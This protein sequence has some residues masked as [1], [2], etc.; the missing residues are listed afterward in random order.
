M[1]T[2]LKIIPGNVK[3]VLQERWALLY[4]TTRKPIPVLV[5]W[6]EDDFKDRNFWSSVISKLWVF[7]HL[8]VSYTESTHIVLLLF[9]ISDASISILCF[10]T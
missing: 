8:I 2:V 5:T 9:L 3:E 6:K 1:K 4:M 7:K 10:Y